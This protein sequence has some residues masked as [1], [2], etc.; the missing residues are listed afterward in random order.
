MSFGLW[1]LDFGLSNFGNNRQFVS[2]HVFSDKASRFRFSTV[3]ISPFSADFQTN[4]E[5]SESFRRRLRFAGNC[6]NVGAKESGKPALMINF[7][8]EKSEGHAE[9]FCEIPFAV[10]RLPELSGGKIRAS[11]A[12]IFRPC[13]NASERPEQS[14]SRRLSD[15]APP[16]RAGFFPELFAV[17]DFRT[18]ND[19]RVK[20]DVVVEKP[21]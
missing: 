6:R 9:S 4:S 7:V 13:Y 12:L 3:L 17:V 14:P 20:L 19:L 1:T 8:A 11:R 18:E 15:N 2:S 10:F 5:M 16:N 21:F